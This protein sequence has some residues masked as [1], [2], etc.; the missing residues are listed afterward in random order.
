MANTLNQT[1]VP[2]TGYVGGYGASYISTI[3]LAGAVPE[4]AEQIYPELF[5][6]AGEQF[7]LLDMLRLIGNV[8]FVKNSRL[9]AFEEPVV[10]T[11]ITTKFYSVVG[12]SHYVTLSGS[13][14]DTGGRS[15]LRKGDVL[16]F[17]GA[18]FGKDY[19]IALQVVNIHTSG[20][21][22]T[23]TAGTGSNS[24]YELKSKEGL[25]V[26]GGQ[27]LA[28]KVG[29]IG[30]TEAG[31]GAGQPSPRYYT[32]LQRDFYTT[33]VK[34][35]F[36]IEGG[37]KAMERQQVFTI[38]GQPTIWDAGFVNA[39]FSIDRQVDAT[40]WLGALNTGNVTLDNTRDGSS[41]A[42][43]GTKGF[44]PTVAELG[45]SLVLDS[46][47]FNDLADFDDIRTL[48]LSQGVT[49]DT[50]LFLLDP[51]LYSKVEN[52]VYNTIGST[53]GVGL[54]DAKLQMFGVPFRRVMKNN[55]VYYLL[56]SS[57]LSNPEA[58]SAT[59][60]TNNGFVIPIERQ[61]TQ[62]SAPITY[63]GVEYTPES[64]KVM[65][66]NIGVGYLNNNGE[67]RQHVISP[68]YGV[69]GMGFPAAHQY[70]VNEVFFLSEFM[71]FMMGANKV[72][73]VR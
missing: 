29:F 17:A 12:D 57:F 37:V 46:G 34:E 19:P 63:G 27:D 21:F 13:D 43:L 25:S 49:A 66:P 24:V 38:N 48:H 7:K 10:K 59:G 2:V 5:K 20:T 62:V 35:T 58:I 55:R 11:K 53:Q 71:L 69:N 51:V 1:E 3:S 22:G 56:E 33:I 31:R 47:N 50:N 61:A 44:I 64:G 39:E 42:T 45:Q 67:N 23:I 72:V 6:S 28:N 65:L 30:G 68:V 18:I 70:D 52:T 32:N 54:Y 60:F 40:L 14:Y 36:T 9:T 15:P 4:V 73:W 8:F 26:A 16:Y 41:T